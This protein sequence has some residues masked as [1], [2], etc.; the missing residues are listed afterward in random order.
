MI[1][2]KLKLNEDKT[3]C[4]LFGTTNALKNFEHFNQIQIGPSTIE[5]VTMVKDLGVDIDN[6]LSM[7]NHVLK[8][9]K[10]CNHHIR[11]ISFIRKYLNQ[12]TLKTLI[13]SHVMSRLDYCNSIYYGLP[14]YQL[15]KLQNV[16]NRAAR[17]IKGTRLSDRIT[18][19]LLTYTGSQ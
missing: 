6:K 2:K 9:V 18:P 10:V 7:K 8:T 4:M 5:I 11:N 15:K 13:N 17:L 16:Q 19:V 1:R 14:N 3:E 12:N